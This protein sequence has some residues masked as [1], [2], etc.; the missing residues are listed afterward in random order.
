MQAWKGVNRRLVFHKPPAHAVPKYDPAAVKPVRVQMVP[1]PPRPVPPADPLSPKRLAVERAVHRFTMD[2]LRWKAHGIEAELD[3]KV[4]PAAEAPELL[5][6]HWLRTIRERGLASLTLPGVEGQSP[7]DVDLLRLKEILRPS[8]G[9]VSPPPATAAM[10]A[11]R[12]RGGAGG[13]GVPSRS[14]SG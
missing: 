1:R 12:P 7:V 2:H 11:A 9:P 8:D 3:T 14:G 5:A 6:N 13:G 4:G 10:G